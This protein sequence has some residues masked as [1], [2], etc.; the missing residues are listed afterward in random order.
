MS[1]EIEINIA[2][3]MKDINEQKW[4][5]EQ[6]YRIRPRFLRVGTYMYRVMKDTLTTTYI[7][8]NN[9][10]LNTFMD[11]IICDTPTVEDFSVE[12]F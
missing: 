4:R 7:R 8:V 2:D 9:N 6:K 12:V 3:L 10:I 5:F 11:L 1:E